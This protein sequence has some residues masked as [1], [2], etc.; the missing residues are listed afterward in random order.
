MRVAVIGLGAIGCLLA[1]YLKRAGCDVTGVASGPTGFAIKER[2][3]SLAFAGTMISASI[4]VV[5]DPGEL[6][7]LDL[8][9]MCT[10]MFDLEAAVSSFTTDTPRSVPILT[11]Q[12]G[13]D[14]PDIIAQKVGS[15]RTLIG[16]A[17]TFAKLS[18]PGRVS[19]SGK[20]PRFLIGEYTGTQSNRVHA[21]REMFIAAG[22]GAPAAADAR[23]ELWQKFAF[24]TAM[25][26]ITAASGRSLGEVREDGR[27]REL[28]VRA[29][30]E[31][32]EVA[33]AAAISLPE[34]LVAWAVEIVR[35]SPPHATSSLATDLKAGRRSENDWLSGTVVR[36]GRSLGIDTPI[37]L[38][39]HALIA[40]RSL[41]ASKVN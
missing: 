4:E 26:G 28:F 27:A 18:A 8:I 15:S 5:A 41:G 24:V 11:I 19:L 31:V 13:V 38:A 39:F 25:A 35:T 32:R 34:T 6:G 33:Y 7:P 40:L 20:T 23:T 37:H 14:A 1:A 2:G 21:I 36:I 10:K 29:V 22:L 3:I 9:I 16:S 17:Y 30:E 12:N